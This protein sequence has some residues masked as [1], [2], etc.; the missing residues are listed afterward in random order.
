MEDFIFIFCAIQCFT[1]AYFRAQ[2]QYI[3]KAHWNSPQRLSM[4]FALRAG[5]WRILFGEISI[6]IVLRVFN[7]VSCRPA[8]KQCTGKHLS[9]HSTLVHL[10][11]GQINNGTNGKLGEPRL[12]KTKIRILRLLTRWMHALYLQARH[13]SQYQW[14]PERYTCR[15]AEPLNLRPGLRTL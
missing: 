10:L 2:P 7:E 6:W 13:L 11:A 1:N 9:G 12:P 4:C 3:P 15:C 5:C 8:S 14:K